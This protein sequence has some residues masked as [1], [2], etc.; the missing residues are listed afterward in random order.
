MAVS[1]IKKF[2]ILVVD[3]DDAIREG[4]S[5]VL[6]IEGY[7]VLVARNTISAIRLLEEE[8][9]DLVITDIL[10]PGDSGLTLIQEIMLSN[11]QAKIICISGGGKNQGLGLLQIA[12]KFGAIKTLQKPISV[13]MLIETVD[14]VLKDN[15]EI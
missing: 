1:L 11:D 9:V 4:F 7:E 14:Q 8:K 12:Q 6:K 3:D 13:D 2:R 10:M 5:E 15:Y